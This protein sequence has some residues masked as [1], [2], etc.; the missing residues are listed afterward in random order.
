MIVAILLFIFIT[1][2]F[3]HRSHFQTLSHPDLL[4][5]PHL[6]SHRGAHSRYTENTMEAFKYAKALGFQMIELDVQLSADGEV[7]VFHDTDLQRMLAQD[8]MIQDMSASDIFLKLKAPL[9]KDVLNS[10]DVPEFVNIEIKNKKIWSSQIEK[11][12]ARIIEQ[13]NGKKKILISSFNPITIFKMSWLLPE[14]LRALLVTQEP[15]LENKIYLRKMWFAPYCRCH[16]LNLDNKSFDQNEIRN[17]IV[18]G[19]SVSLWTVNSYDLWS[20]Y[21]SLGVRSI[22]T[23]LE[24]TKP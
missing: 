4:T 24:K 2:L 20:V 23:D 13:S 21:F 19:V 18:R 6:Q 22:I 5:L 7:V 10:A 16:M 12:V 15:S 14:T 3:W 9:L 1:F 17:L 8:L 11:A